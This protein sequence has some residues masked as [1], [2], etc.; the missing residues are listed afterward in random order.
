[1]NIIRWQILEAAVSKY[2]YLLMSTKVYNNFG[3]NK[4][5][6]SIIMLNK[7]FTE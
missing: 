2:I 6:R 5:D 1:M 7:T 3:V 4:H